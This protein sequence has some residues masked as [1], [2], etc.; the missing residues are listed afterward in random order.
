[1]QP[2]EHDE[3]RNGSCALQSCS[4]WF[5][6]GLLMIKVGHQ[7]IAPTGNHLQWPIGQAWPNLDVKLIWQGL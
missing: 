3:V 1:M 5:D 2:R 4:S 6:A 7:A